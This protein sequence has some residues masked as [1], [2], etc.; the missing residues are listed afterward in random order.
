LLTLSHVP[1]T[2]LLLKPNSLT[3]KKDKRPK[4]KKREMQIFFG[5][6]VLCLQEIYQKACIIS[7]DF[8]AENLVLNS[9]NSLLEHL[10]QCCLRVCASINPQHPKKTSSEVHICM[11]GAKNRCGQLDGYLLHFSPPPPPPPTTTPP[12]LRL[13]PL[14]FPSC[15]KLPIGWRSTIKQPSTYRQAAIYVPSSSH[16]GTIK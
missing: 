4:G 10:Q 1:L 12:L 15:H 9:S 7:H 3:H 2:A 13:I 14:Q 5:D 8:N 16:L 11:L 6:L